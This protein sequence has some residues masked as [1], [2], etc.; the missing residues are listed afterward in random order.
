MVKVHGDK[1]RRAGDGRVKMIDGSVCAAVSPLP[2]AS[3]VQNNVTRLQKGS[4]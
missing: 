2:D 3:V 4:V 1:C